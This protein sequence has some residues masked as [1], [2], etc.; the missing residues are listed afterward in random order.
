MKQNNFIVFNDI[1]DQIINK[2]SNN[3]N[4]NLLSNS[5]VSNSSNNNNNDNNINFSLIDI[6]VTEVLIMCYSNFLIH[7]GFSEIHYFV[8]SCR[9]R[10]SNNNSNNKN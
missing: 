8:D 7:F 4:N 5:L 2:Y 1:K 9:S 6:F 3:N 10:F